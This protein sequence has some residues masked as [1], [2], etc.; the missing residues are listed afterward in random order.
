MHEMALCESVVR[1]LEE[2][3]HEQGFAKV[4]VV[5][6]AIGQLSQVELDSFRFCFGAVVQGTLA[7]GAQLDIETPAGKA[8]CLDCRRD[9]HLARLG[10]ACPDCGGYA[11]QITGGEE[12]R[13]TELEVE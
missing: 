3:A 13:I 10:E 11:L 5:R 2:Q 4:T 1:I 6:M 12:M 9:I 8:W 7:A